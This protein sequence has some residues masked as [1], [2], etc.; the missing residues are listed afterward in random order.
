MGQKRE[1]KPG[2]LFG[3]EVTRRCNLTCPHCFTAAGAA[4]HP[5]PT[6]PEVRALME[7][8]V[9]A[10]TRHLAFSGGEPL[11]RRDLEELMA[12]GRAAGMKSFS[13]VSNGVLA[14]PRRVAQLRRAG[15]VSVQVSLDGVDVRDHRAIR[16]CSAEAYF[17]AMRAIRLF[18]EAGVEV[19]VATILV[20]PNVE[21]LEEMTLF[22]QALG[23]RKLRY[24]SFVPTGRGAGDGVR[25]EHAAEPERLDAFL[26][27]LRR[28]RAGKSPA[29][30]LVID[31]GVGPWREDGRF[32]CVAGR[33]VAYI[34]SEGDLY[35]CPSLMHPPFRVG[36]V[37]REGLA[38]LLASPA[39]HRVRRLRR[40][41][42]AEPCR[43]CPTPRCSGGCRG[44]A[45]AATGDVRA[46]PAYCNY[47]RRTGA[48]AEAPG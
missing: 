20:G 22:G 29:V 38:A 24:C 5:G 14:S 37:F 21:R 1:S 27:G 23:V 34:T 18:R 9:A 48:P 16:G 33:H 32:R 28:Y 40:R 35:P 30:D 43:S 8:L 45:Y 46:A 41:E 15:L 12:D 10:G 3:L 39:L 17:R 26:E 19:D 13:M 25:A 44:A 42:L 4:A 11:A 47:L 6:R 31:H 7:Q 2:L 36:N